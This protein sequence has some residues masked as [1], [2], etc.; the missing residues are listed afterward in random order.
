LDRRL[1]ICKNSRRF[2]GQVQAS[3]LGKTFLM[4]TVYVWLLTN[5]QGKPRSMDFYSFS[6][7]S[8]SSKKNRKKNTKF[9]NKSLSWKFQIFHLDVTPYKACPSDWFNR[10]SFSLLNFET[11]AFKTHLF[12]VFVPFEWI[13]EA[14]R[15]LLFQ[16]QT[17]SPDMKAGAVITNM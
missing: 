5:R 7:F 1:K 9:Q 13:L 17:L 16:Q 6:C 8:V 2:Y 12:V 10:D 11:K 3:N 15:L 14:K 4:V